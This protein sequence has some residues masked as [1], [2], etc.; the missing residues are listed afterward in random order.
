M[1]RDMDLI[2]TIMLEIEKQYIPGT[3]II[4]NFKVDALTREEAY[5]YLV[6]FEDAKLIQKLDKLKNG[7]GCDNVYPGNLSYYGYDF[8]DKIRDDGTW[9]KTV[10]T[11]AEKGLDMSIK[12][13]GTI[14]TAFIT[15]ATEGAVSAIMKNGGQI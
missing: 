13:I 7:N 9:Q 2:R 11:I 1:K 6:L 3:D 10:K 8:L 4:R 5:E 14:A 15:A 12:T